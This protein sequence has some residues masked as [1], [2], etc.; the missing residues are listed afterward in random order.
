MNN[1]VLGKRMDNLRNRIDV[2]II[3]NKKDYLT[4]TSK[5]SFMSQKIFDND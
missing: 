3:G 5:P 2:R 1:A 4:W